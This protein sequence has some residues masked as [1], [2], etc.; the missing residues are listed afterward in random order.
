MIADFGLSRF[1]TAETNMHIVCGTLS[2][3]APEVLKGQVTPYGHHINT[4]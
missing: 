3:I 1:A 2:Y 4:F